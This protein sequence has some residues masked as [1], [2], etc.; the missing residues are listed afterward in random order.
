[1][2]RLRRRQILKSSEKFYRPWANYFTKF[3][4]AYE[5]AGIPLWGVSMQNEPMATQKWESCIFTAEEERDF[6]KFNLG[7]TMLKAGLGN[8]KIIGWDHNRDLIYQRAQTYF[9]DP[10]AAKYAWGIGFHWYETWSGGE[11]MFENVKRI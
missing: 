4:K 5:A 6:L 9:N 10:E 1:M 3:I 11:P 8:K 7:P 2:H